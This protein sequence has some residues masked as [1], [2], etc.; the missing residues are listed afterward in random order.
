MDI[1][2]ECQELNGTTVV[3]DFLQLTRK[4]KNLIW[5]DKS[6]TWSEGQETHEF[7]TAWQKH[8]QEVLHFLF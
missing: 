7:D 8:I 5:H 3:D 6:A 1:A 2:A 4:E